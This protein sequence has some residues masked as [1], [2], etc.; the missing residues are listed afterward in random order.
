M[1]RE[2]WEFETHSSQRVFLSAWGSQAVPWM[3][4]LVVGGVVHAGRLDQIPLTPREGRPI[5]CTLRGRGH[6]VA[7]DVEAARA[8]GKIGRALTK[9]AEITAGGA[10]FHRDYRVLA[11]GG[12]GGPDRYVALARAS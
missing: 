5:I 9:S 11:F 1:Q 10:I 3:G 7:S 2:N 4:L 12:G 6:R 8:S